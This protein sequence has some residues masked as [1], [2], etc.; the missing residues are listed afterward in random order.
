M[1]RLRVRLGVLVVIA[2]DVPPVGGCSLTFPQKVLADY[3][4]FTQ[5]LPHLL[6]V[7]SSTTLDQAHWKRIHVR[8]GNTGELPT[9]QNKTIQTYNY[10]RNRQVRQGRNCQD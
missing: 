2:D 9:K 1:V 8:K 6:Q 10:E 3:F 5:L 4:Q 7:E